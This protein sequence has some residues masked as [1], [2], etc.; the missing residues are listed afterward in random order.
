MAATTGMLRRRTVEAAVRGI[1]LLLR[2]APIVVEPGDDAALGALGVVIWE[3]RLIVVEQGHAH[4]TVGRRKLQALI[5]RVRRVGLDAVERVLDVLID[6][7]SCVRKGCK[8]L[9]R[10]EAKVIRRTGV[11]AQAYIV[12]A[13]VVQSDAL[14]LAIPWHHGG[15][16]PERVGEVARQPRD[17][18]PMRSDTLHL[19]RQRRQHQIVRNRRRIVGPAQQ[20]PRASTCLAAHRHAK[21]LLEGLVIVCAVI[22]ISAAVAAAATTANAARMRCRS[23]H[24]NRKDARIVARRVDE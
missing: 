23:R 20:Q 4:T 19:R 21:P 17:V 3:V 6:A 2:H 22:A 5:R 8:R 16:S 11:I 18:C 10:R 24:P 7:G 13:A 15:A 9:R 14:V 12:R 1:G